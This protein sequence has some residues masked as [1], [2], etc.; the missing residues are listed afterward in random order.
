MPRFQILPKGAPSSSAI[1]VRSAAQ[2]L[3]I[4]QRLESHEA[5]VLRDGNY[6]FSARLGDNGTWCIFQRNSEERSSAIAPS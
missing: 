3:P 6:C 2:V 4:V 1:I 5:D